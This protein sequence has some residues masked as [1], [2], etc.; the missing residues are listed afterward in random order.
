MTT[1]TLTPVVGRHLIAGR[2]LGSK[3]HVF[4]SRSP[5]NANEIIGEFPRGRAEEVERAVATPP[6]QHPVSA[7]QKE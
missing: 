7:S 4:E 6:A 5:A 2:W 3:G 1:A